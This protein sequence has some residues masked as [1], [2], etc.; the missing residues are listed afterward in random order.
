MT[1]SLVQS[2]NGIVHNLTPSHSLYHQQSAYV[3]AT[4]MASPIR[5]S[6]HV[7]CIQQSSPYTNIYD[8]APVSPLR[9]LLP[10]SHP[11]Q[12]RWENPGGWGA[13]HLNDMAPF[14]LWDEQNH[15]FRHPSGQDWTWIRNKFGEGTV[16]ISAW[17]IC[18]ETASPPQPIPLTLGT[19][20]VIFVRP[21]EMFREPIPLSGYSNPRVPDPCPTVRWPQL[22]NPTKRQAVAVLTAIAPLARVRAAMFLPAWTIFELEFGDGR[23]YEK[24]SLPGSWQAEQHS[25]TTEINRFLAP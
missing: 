17:L 12:K 22:T 1:K 18:M 6:P 3:M 13:R 14:T 11:E 24:R 2:G 20:P 10:H 15:K 5:L 8:N 4:P 19:M 23:N 25:T 21:G 9:D 16:H 7:Q